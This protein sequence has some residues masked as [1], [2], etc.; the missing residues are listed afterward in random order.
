[1]SNFIIVNDFS[2]PSLFDGKNNVKLLYDVLQFPTE[3]SR[4]VLFVTKNTLVCELSKDA[5]YVAYD[6]KSRNKHNCVSLDGTF[7][8]MNGSFSGGKS[9]ISKRVQ[10]I[11]SQMSENLK[12]RKKE[13]INVLKE[14]QKYLDNQSELKS[15]ESKQNNLNWKIKYLK[16]A[17]KKMVGIFLFSINVQFYHLILFVGIRV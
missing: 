8:K 17:S 16:D 6:L 12:T 10:L 4:A 7:Y 2:D 11:D 1:M 3:I 13:I 9:S 5:N 15:L 14:G